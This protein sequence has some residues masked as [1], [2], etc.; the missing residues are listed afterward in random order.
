MK[1][2]IHSFLTL[3]FFISSTTF[4]SATYPEKE[5]RIAVSKMRDYF[6][7]AVAGGVGTLAILRLMHRNLVKRNFEG[8]FVSDLAYFWK[9][10]KDRKT[11]S[12]CVQNTK[13]H[14][15]NLLS[16]DAI[17]YSLIRQ[18][19]ISSGESYNRFL[20]EIKPEIFP[21]RDME[22]DPRFKG[23]FC[24]DVKLKKAYRNLIYFLSQP[25]MAILPNNA[26]QH[27]HIGLGPYKVEYF[28]FDKKKIV[29]SLV[30][31]DPKY[32]Y[33]KISITEVE[34]TSNAS[35][36]IEQ[37][38]LDLYIGISD[39][40]KIPTNSIT[41]VTFLK[42]LAID[43]LVFNMKSKICSDSS[44]RRD[45]SGLI[46][47]YLAQKGSDNGAFHYHPYFMPKGIFPGFYY[48]S[49]KFILDE[50]EFVRRWKGRMQES[51]I[52]IIGSINELSENDYDWLQGILARIGLNLKYVSDYYGLSD[53]YL[54]S[55]AYDMAFLGWMGRFD[56]PEAFFAMIYG[57][58]NDQAFDK[59][60]VKNFKNEIEEIYKIEDDVERSRKLAE[61]LANF[62]GKNIILPLYTVDLPVLHSIF[63]K[64]PS[65]K[66]R[67]HLNIEEIIPLGQA[68]N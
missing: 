51:K 7:P 45:F 46:R 66:F 40:Q 63:I 68:F 28:E 48:R 34:R 54:A 18:E 15:Q 33:D 22:K 11:Y 42:S 37:K 38:K 58:I 19:H 64:V 13:F 5:L 4:A 60:T 61:S 43:H 10:S 3:H 26:D 65:S 16:I 32:Y 57:M 39:M 17:R 1:I 2:L 31:K 49:P 30:K 59:I 9:I 29:F 20:G 25:D 35:K 56:R 52:T 50:Q 27:D 12:F 6:D 14:D 55:G 44:F 23:G 41:R 47:Y 21:N 67:F 24:F 53:D 62:E 8:Q 36:M